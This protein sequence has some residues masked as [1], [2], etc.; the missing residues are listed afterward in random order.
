MSNFAGAFGPRLGSNAASLHD[1]APAALD[2]PVDRLGHDPGADA[3]E[4]AAV[5]LG[6]AQDVEPQRRVLEERRRAPRQSSADRLAPPSPSRI[7]ALVSGVTATPLDCRRAAMPCPVASST[8]FARARLRKA[9]L[10]SM[11]SRGGRLAPKDPGGSSLER[12]RQQRVDPPG[13]VELRSPAP[14][15]RPARTRTGGASRRSSCSAAAHRRRGRRSCPRTRTAG[16]ASRCRRRTP[17]SS[18]SRAGSCCARAGTRR[19]RTRSASSAP[20]SAPRRARTTLRPFGEHVVDD[21]RL[22]DPRQVVVADHPLVVL[23]DERGGRSLEAL[24]GRH[25]A[26]RRRRRGCGSAMNARWVWATARFSSLRGSGSSRACSR[27]CAEGRSPSWA[28]SRS[29]ADRLGPAH[30]QL[31]GRRRGRSARTPRSPGPAP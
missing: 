25:G 14:S 16:T 31:A 8:I 2:R 1:R 18:C 24:R 15:A 11:S 5:E 23:D 9:R 6:L 26:E 27:R 20:R 19:R 29:A 3:V 21:G 22:A 30:P 7:C 17:G 10:A 4:P 12:V 28:S 13:A